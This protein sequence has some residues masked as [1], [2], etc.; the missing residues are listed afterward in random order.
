MHNVNVVAEIGWN[1]MGNISLAAEMIEAAKLSGA[2]IV[3][4]QYWDPKYLKKG[5][6]D[7]D[8]RRDI[9]NK[10]VLSEKK[11]RELIDISESNGCGFLISVFG[12]KGATFVRELGIRNVKIPSHET[13]NLALIEYCASHFDHIFFSAG[14]SKVFE[15]QRANDIL[16]AGTASYNLMHCVSSYPCESSSANLQRINWLKE[17]CS[18]VGYSDHTQSLVVPAAAVS[19][20]CTVIEKHFTTDKS[21]PGR[22]NKFALNAS[23]FKEMVLNIRDVE[24]S[25]IDRGLDFQAIEQDTVENYRG[26][27]EPHDYSD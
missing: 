26:R 15:V 20:G 23:E 21:L 8:G 18:D 1:H 4:F 25:M 17:L 7:H 3:K 27:W 14:A 22:D 6:W 12:T 5:A 24:A 10:A 19:L 16:K 11:I 2:D 13:A 9:Y